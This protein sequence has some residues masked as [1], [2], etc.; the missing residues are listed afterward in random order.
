[1]FPDYLFVSYDYDEAD[2]Q[3]QKYIIPLTEPTLLS[4]YFVDIENTQ[5]ESN[6]SP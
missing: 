2:L 6:T 1:M 4:E 3:T 5:L